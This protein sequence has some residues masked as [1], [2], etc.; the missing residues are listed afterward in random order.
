MHV[1]SLHDF[2]K[3]GC[4]S[5]INDKTINNLPRWGHFQPNFRRPLVAK[6]LMGPKK[7]GGEMIVR[8]TSIIVQNLVEIKR[9]T[10]AWEYKVWY[11][12]FLPAGCPPSTMLCDGIRK[13]L[14][15]EMMATTSSSIMQS[16][17]EIEQ[18]TSVWG[19]KMWCF[20]CL[21]RCRPSR[22]RHF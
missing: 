17:A 12:P 3:F 22:R 7:F 18:R 10:S 19:D 1:L 4:F 15:G 16:L 5:L 11:F 14:G 9:C 8:T 13:T 21:L 6:L 2:A 20:W